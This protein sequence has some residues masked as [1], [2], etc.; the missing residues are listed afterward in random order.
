MGK[1]GSIIPWR[2]LKALLRLLGSDFVGILCSDRWRVYDEWPLMR[3][4]VC[5]AH[6]KRNWQKLVERGGKAQA[7]GQACLEVHRRV[8]ALWHL[9]RGGGIS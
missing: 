6:L 3:R 8:F 1:T 2:N 4:Q 5:W 9:Y 7:I